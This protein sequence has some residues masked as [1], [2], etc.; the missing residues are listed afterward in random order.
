MATVF[1]DHSPELAAS[2]R[3]HLG[4]VIANVGSLGYLRGEELGAAKMPQR[5]AVDA[6]P[7]IVGLLH[8]IP[9]GPR[10]LR[11]S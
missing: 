2:G 10:A 8:A 11:R 9:L 6:D 5:L 7:A 4:F 3:P 1:R